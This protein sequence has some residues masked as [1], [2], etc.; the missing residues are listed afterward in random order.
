MINVNIQACKSRSVCQ[1]MKQ[2]KICWHVTAA[3]F[4]NSN[5][6]HHVKENVL[7]NSG[8]FLQ[9]WQKSTG[10]SETSVAS[11]NKHKDIL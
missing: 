11:S 9:L 7:E 4:R 2:E 1:V 8:E 10:L 6:S 5:R 3:I